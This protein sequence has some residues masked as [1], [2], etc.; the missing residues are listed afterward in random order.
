MNTSQMQNLL[1]SLEAQLQ[2]LQA[3]ASGTTTSFVFTCNLSLW[4]AGNDVKQLQLFLI[5]QSSGPAA[6][7]LAKHGATSVFGMLTFN[8]LIEFQESVGISPASGYFGPKTRAY[9]NGL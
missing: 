4:S 3:K 5:A 9:V 6:Q 7:R 2:A 8:A 1:A